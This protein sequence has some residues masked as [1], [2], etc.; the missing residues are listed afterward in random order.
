MPGCVHRFDV[1]TGQTK[2]AMR[3]AMLSL[4]SGCDERPRCSGGKASAPRAADL[5][6][7]PAF[8]TDLFPEA[9]PF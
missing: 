8:S 9:Q 3:V 4:R 1:T 7:I 5:G 2:A 6:S